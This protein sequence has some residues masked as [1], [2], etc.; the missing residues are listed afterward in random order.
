VSEYHYYEFRAIDRPTGEQ[1]RAEVRSLSI[2]ALG[3]ASF[4]GRLRESDFF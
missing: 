3:K 1:Q 2:K 4:L